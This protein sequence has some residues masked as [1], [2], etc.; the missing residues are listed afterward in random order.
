MS[1]CSIVGLGD[2]GHSSLDPVSVG[3][4]TLHGH[5]SHH[6]EI[7]GDSDGGQDSL[8]LKGDVQR[9]VVGVVAHYLGV[10]DGHQPH[11]GD[12]GDEHLGVRLFQVLVV[13]VPSASFNEQAMDKGTIVRLLGGVYALGIG[14][15]LEVELDGID[16]DL[17]LSGVVLFHTSQERVN[18]METRNPE[19]RRM[20]V[21]NPA[22]VL[23]ESLQDI[24]NERGEGLERVKGVLL[25]WPGYQVIVE[26]VS[27][28]F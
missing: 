11:D 20:A 2:H 1:Q 4:L 16:G 26:G 28:L 18:E 21:V 7:V 6:H 23:L 5:A 27:N 17:V 13:G 8:T 14:D 25:P 15:D 24:Y 3:V 19:A 22:L 9:A 10:L 12:G